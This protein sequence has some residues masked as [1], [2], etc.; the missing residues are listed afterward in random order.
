MSLRD[1]LLPLAEQFFKIN[2]DVKQI[3]ITED[4]HCWY[5]EI[6]AKRFCKEKKE[7]LK[8]TSVDFDDKSEGDKDLTPKQ[9]L[10]KEAKDLEIDFDENITVKKLKGLIE[11]RKLENLKLQAIDLEID[12]DENISFEDLTELI[13]K[14]QE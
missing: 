2:S 7:Y 3:F 13:K 8:F 9:K 12:F 5:T 6:E 11:V 1:S 4:K 14:T 10:Q